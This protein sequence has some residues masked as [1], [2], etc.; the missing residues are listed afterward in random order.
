[1]PADV[2]G[3]KHAAMLSW[4]HT[5][6]HHTVPPSAPHRLLCQGCHSEECPLTLM[7]TKH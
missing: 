3:R 6:E 2:C 1:M 4:S 5:T 7:T